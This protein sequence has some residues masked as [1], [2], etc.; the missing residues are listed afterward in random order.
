MYMQGLSNHLF[1][2]IVNL[3]QLKS[4]KNESESRVAIII[5]NLFF[6][7][8]AINTK[9]QVLVVKKIINKLFLAVFMHTTYQYAKTLCA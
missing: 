4:E 3:Y 2:L 5:T 1:M 8:I 7:V 6:F 9:M